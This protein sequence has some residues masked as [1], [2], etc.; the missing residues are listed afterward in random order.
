MNFKVNMSYGC[1][2]VTWNQ[3]HEFF[4]GGGS[5]DAYL[6]NQVINHFTFYSQKF[7]ISCWNNMELWYVG[8][9]IHCLSLNKHVLFLYVFPRTSMPISSLKHQTWTGKKKEQK[10]FDFWI[11]KPLALKSNIKTKGCERENRKRPQ[12][13]SWWDF[14]TSSSL[15]RQR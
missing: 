12:G 13:S 8:V 15:N 14:H 7:S 3:L 6:Q 4:F 9:C 11:Q 10:I 2:W 1:F 5:C